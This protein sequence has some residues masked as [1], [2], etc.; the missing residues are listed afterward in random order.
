[1]NAVHSCCVISTVFIWAAGQAL[2]RRGLHSE[3]RCAG[4]GT[5]ACSEAPGSSGNCTDCMARRSHS[6]WPSCR[7]HSA[8]PPLQPCGRECRHA[9]RQA[10]RYRKSVL[11]TH[12]QTRTHSY[13]VCSIL[14]RSL[15]RVRLPT[16]LN[17]DRGFVCD[18][19][20]SRSHKNP[21]SLPGGG[22]PLTVEVAALHTQRGCSN[23][24][25]QGAALSFQIIWVLKILCHG[26]HRM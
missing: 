9:D 2:G 4:Q 3:S 15:S 23:P 20:Q 26:Q 11:V 12:T 6:P 18:C 10:D 8:S 22:V 5:R 7:S 14:T 21:P 24:Q 25:Q 1:M 17:R 13:H 19:W 16:I